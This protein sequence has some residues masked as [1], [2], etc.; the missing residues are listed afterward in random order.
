[1]KQILLCL[2][3]AMSSALAADSNEVAKKEI[4]HLMSHLASSGCQFDRNGSW[5]NAARAVSHLRR[6]YEYLL[7]R[8][9]VPNTE[10]F[11]KAAASESSAS[12]KPYLVKCDGKPEV[13]SAVWFGEELAKFREGSN[14]AADPSSNGRPSH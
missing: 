5:Y 1:M 7:D 3:F 2:L 12:G 4:E 13:K 14:N 11:I 6:K 10:A 8:N 9:L